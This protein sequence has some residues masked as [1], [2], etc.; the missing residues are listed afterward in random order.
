MSARVIYSLG[1]RFAGHGI[2]TTAHHA[3]RG[4]ERNGL[5][6]RLLCGSCAATEIPAERI[7]SL[8]LA[9]RALKRAAVRD[10]SGRLASL[11]SR[12]YDCWSARRLE[13]CDVFHGWN[14]HCLGAMERAR[15]LGAQTWVECAS[16]HPTPR[17]Q[18]LRE[19]HERLGL[20]FR[21]DD[22]ARS[23]AVA[24]L[25]RADRIL[26][27]SERA[28]QSFLDEGVAA[29]RLIQLPF[30]ADLQRF[31]PP[32]ERPP[33][34][35]RLLFVG[36]C[37]PRKGVVYLLEAWRSLAWQDAELWIAGRVPREMEPVL[38]PLRDLPGLRWLD[39]AADPAPLYAGTDVFV[40]PTLEEGSA[41]VGYEALASGL[42]MVTTPNAGSVVREG[43]EGFLVPPR[44]V[45]ALC[46]R[47]ERLRADP[48]LRRELGRAA[49]ERAEQFSWTR[50]GDALAEAVRTHTAPATTGRP[51]CASR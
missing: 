13:P 43:R 30:G 20:P 40:L 29:E 37:G 33:G 2:G 18:L 21:S 34:P 19:E 24:E 27:P 49:R 50:Y 5:L 45:D 8:G 1:A 17:T 39:F 26:V 14:G 6:L 51:S 35:F 15:A 31:R 28:E 22:G 9:S 44:D 47:L 25:E 23:R 46:A 42:P 10:P 41:L 36:D 16:W 38:R 32:A 7:R 11:H 12:L 4:L 3:V 48:E